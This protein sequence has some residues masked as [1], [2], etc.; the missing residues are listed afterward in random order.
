MSAKIARLCQ[1]VQPDRIVWTVTH[2]ATGMPA[3]P[4]GIP[5]VLD[6]VDECPAEIE[7]RYVERSDAIVTVSPNLQRRAA[8]V[9]RRVE[10]IP[11]GVVLDR[12]SAGWR[13][14]AKRQL[15]LEG[16]V[17]VS[18][19]GMTC[20]HRLYFLEAFESF[21]RQVPQAVL[22]LVGGSSLEGRIRERIARMNGEVRWI[23]PVA[24]DEV[25]VYFNAT[26][27]GLYPGDDNDYYRLACPLK[28]IEYSAAGAQVVSSPVDWYRAGWPNVRTVKP[29][30]VAFSDAMREAHLRPGAATD[31]SHLEWKSVAGRLEEFL[32]SVRAMRHSQSHDQDRSATGS[33]SGGQ[34]SC[35]DRAGGSNPAG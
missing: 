32:L 20:S 5:V 19:I 18:L 2:Y 29:E 21:A 14:S 25:P 10:C 12:Y 27:I 1:E 28:V 17:V 31:V 7:R 22:V 34:P 4:E 15:G 11:N 3:L 13:E 6:H 23:G 24:F 26:D 16:R 8:E 30:V 33:R 9:H 35:G